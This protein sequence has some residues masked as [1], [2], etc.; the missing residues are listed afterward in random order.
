MRSALQISMTFQEKLIRSG[1]FTAV[2]YLC[3][4]IIVTLIAGLSFWVE[5]F[6]SSYNVGALTTVGVVFVSG[7]IGILLMR[8]LVPRYGLKPIFEQDVLILM[9]GLLFIA[10]TINK[11]MLIIGMAITSGA[12]AVYFFENYKLQVNAAR[13]GGSSAL[14]LF[15][16]AL[17]PVVSMLALVLFADYGLL[18][19]RIIFAHYIAIAFWVWVQRLGLHMDYHDAPDSIIHLVH[20]YQRAHG[21]IP[22][23]NTKNSVNSKPTVNTPSVSSQANTTSVN[24]QAPTTQD[25]KENGE[26]TSDKEEKTSTE[27]Q[28]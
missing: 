3:A 21:H 5:Y 12:V 14:S 8:F 22:T 4:G 24:S 19:I 11:A 9:I 7:V 23:S 20:C 6:E 16:W 26:Q 18:T 28:K 10:L 17:G 15:G 27:T 1:I 25:V 2:G 13:A